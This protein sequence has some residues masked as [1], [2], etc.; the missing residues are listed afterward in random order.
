M[1]EQ[2][3]ARKVL[4]TRKSRRLNVRW[5][6]CRPRSCSFNSCGYRRERRRPVK[7]RHSSTS[8]RC[9]AFFSTAGSLECTISTE[10]STTSRLVPRSGVRQLP[11]ALLDSRPHGR[12]VLEINKVRLPVLHVVSLTEKMNI[13]LSAFVPEN[14]VSRDGFDSPVPRQPAHPHTCTPAE[15]GAYLRDSSR[16]PRRRPFIYL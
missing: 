15:S 9:S 13:S 16:V 1:C 7:S 5:F 10:S 4:A 3:N 14:L 6:L 12:P 2:S 11:R 8:R